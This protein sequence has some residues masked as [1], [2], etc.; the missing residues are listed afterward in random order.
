MAL[1]YT[2]RDIW[3]ISYELESLKRGAAALDW[4]IDATEKNDWDCRSSLCW[5]HEVIVK[6]LDTIGTHLPRSPAAEAP[7][8]EQIGCRDHS[9]P[10]HELFSAALAGLHFAKLLGKNGRPLKFIFGEL[11]A[12]VW[13]FEDFLDDAK[14]RCVWIDAPAEDE[15]PESR[16]RAT[17]AKPKA[18]KQKPIAVPAQPLPLAA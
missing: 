18:K 5:L 6:A 11:H 13:A 4:V 10:F 2:A 9:G 15:A 1:E 8:E 12:A 7:T 14:E 17:A 16:K 3:H